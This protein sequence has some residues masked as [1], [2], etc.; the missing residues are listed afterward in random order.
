MKWIRHG[1]SKSSTEKDGKEDR[2]DSPS[3]VL[4]NA[5]SVFVLLSSLGGGGINIPGLYAAGQIGIQ[6]I[7][8]VKVMM[9]NNSVSKIVFICS[10]DETNPAENQI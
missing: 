9:E 5:R 2:P 4:N 6:I 1:R 10:F 8:L 3:P 7:D